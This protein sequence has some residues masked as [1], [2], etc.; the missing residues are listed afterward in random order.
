ML[1]AAVA[2]GK[3]VGGV[4]L[5][6]RDGRVAY[7]RAV[8][9]AD[10]E[11]RRPM[12]ETTPHRLASLTKPIVAAT[13]LALIE[14]GVLGLDDDI[15]RWVPELRPRSGGR[16]AAISVR[17]LLTHTSGLSYAFLEPLGGPYHAAN[18]SDGLD[19]PG[20]SFEEN[21]RRLA[22]VELLAQPGTAFIYSLSFDVLGEV[23]ARAAGAPLPQL[24]ADAITGP[25]ELASLGF[26][27]STDDELATPY[28]DGVGGAA[29][30]RMTDGSYVP[31]AGAGATFAPSRALDP[32]SYPSGGAG[33]VGRADDVLRFLE[34]LRTRRAPLSADSIDAMTRDQIPSLTS[35]LLGDGWG[36]GFGVGVLRDPIAAASPMSAG[37]YRWGGAYGHAWSVD[38]ASRTSTVLLTNTA[39]EGM[40]G[41]LRTDLEVAVHG[42]RG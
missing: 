27:P 3:I 34:A 6:A 1:D 11:A 20:L 5:V 19:Q 36:Y 17:Q 18:I 16:A 26:T 39:F 4:F 35:L 13:A 14:R 8:G 12:R 21:V 32:R 33:M 22:S 23:L 10:R 30:W 40:N 41:Q 7:R 38:P 37:A 25:L 24:V 29:P 42:E 28:G 31:F 2:R 15:A 9:F